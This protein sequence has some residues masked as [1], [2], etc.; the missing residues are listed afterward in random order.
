MKGP[1]A[2]ADVENGGHSVVD[3]DVSESVSVSEF[4]SDI[5]LR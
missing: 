5:T 3:V 1:G 2:K 4:P